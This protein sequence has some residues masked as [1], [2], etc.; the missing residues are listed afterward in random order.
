MQATPEHY[1]SESRYTGYPDGD[2]DR[3]FRHLEEAMGRAEANATALRSNGYVVEHT[4]TGNDDVGVIR[5]YHV[6]EQDGTPIAIIEVRQ[7]HEEGH[8]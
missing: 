2:E 4:D 7:C 1:H 8:V 3:P 5:E 6:A